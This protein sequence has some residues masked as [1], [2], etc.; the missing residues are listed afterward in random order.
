MKLH[1]YFLYRLVREIFKL[2]FMF[3][4]AVFLA[5]TMTI[6]DAYCNVIDD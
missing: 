5:G 6:A 1:R 3:T 4:I 2:P